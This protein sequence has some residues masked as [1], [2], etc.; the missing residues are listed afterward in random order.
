MRRT[1][2]VLTMALAGAVVFGVGGRAPALSD[3][4]DP[5]SVATGDIA[6]AVQAVSSA[7]AGRHLGFDTSKYPGD[8]A[9]K[10]WREDGSYEWVGYY[11]PAPCHRDTT[12]SGKREALA[13]EGW[14][15]AVVY[16]GQQ[17]WGKTPGKA[18]VVTDRGLLEEIWNTNPLL[19]Q[20]LGSLDNPELIVYRI[21]PTRIRYMQEWALEYYDVPFDPPS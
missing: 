12:W 18:E 16:V 11:L 10:A 4:A 20:Y 21:R 8:E 7:A 17:T 9:M 15:L 6:A 1:R 3:L 5:L 2:D 13:A 19:R 14:G